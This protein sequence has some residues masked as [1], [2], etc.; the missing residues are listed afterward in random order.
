[1]PNH[2]A[3]PRHGH[4]RRSPYSGGFKEQSL[5]LRQQIEDGA[6]F[7][8]TA[9]KHSNCS[10]TRSGGDPGH[11]HRERLVPEFDR[12]DFQDEAGVMHGSLKTRFGCYLAEDQS[13]QD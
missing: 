11:I 6:D 12:T 8:G 9:A 4:C 3:E 2:H 5:E 10:S 7:A 13:R 1:M